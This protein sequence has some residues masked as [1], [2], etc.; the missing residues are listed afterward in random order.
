MTIHRVLF[1]GGDV[2]NRTRV[3]KISPTDFYE[4]SRLLGLAGRTT[5]GKD[6]IQPAARTREPLLS[7]CSDVACSIPTF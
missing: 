7:T 6:S 1:I 2:G 4:R 3:R 5:A